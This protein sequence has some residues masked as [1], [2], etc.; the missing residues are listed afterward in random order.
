MVAN[1]EERRKLSCDVIKRR[2]D[3][4]VSK[5]DSDDSDTDTETEDSSEDSTSDSTSTDSDSSSTESDN[6]TDVNE[7]AKTLSPKVAPSKEIG[8]TLAVSSQIQTHEIAESVIEKVER[9]MNEIKL[10]NSGE[11][12]EFELETEK[13]SQEFRAKSSE[14][15]I[16]SESLQSINLT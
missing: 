7:D 8:E 4:I 16:L 10:E 6:S 11:K 2:R 1:E 13:N 9:K 14:S 5:E 15:E 12:S 3:V